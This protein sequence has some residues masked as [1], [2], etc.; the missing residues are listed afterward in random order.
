MKYSD[1]LINLKET[2]MTA[3]HLDVGPLANVIMQL[4]GKPLLT[5]G[6]GGS[7]S[8]A[9]FAA[10]LHEFHTRAIAR[11]V[12]PLEMI[13]TSIEGVGVLCF[14]ASGRNRDICAS[15]KIAAQREVRPLAA[16]TMADQSPLHDLGKIFGYSEITSFPSAD[17]RDG[18]LAVASLIAAAVLVVRA[19]RVVVGD[20]TPLPEDI[21]ELIESATGIKDRSNIADIAEPAVSMSSISVLH[22][23]TLKPVAVDLES[24]F[25]EAA[26]GCLHTADLRNFGH[27]RHHW[28]AKRGEET[29]V[30]AFIGDGQ[31]KLAS[32]TFALLPEASPLTSFNFTGPRDIQALAGLIVGLH[33]AEAAGRVVG[34]DPAKPGVPEFGRKL[35]RL[36]P[37]PSRR[38]L[39]EDHFEV[40]VRRK[41]RNANLTQQDIRDKWRI[42]YETVLSRV[43]SAEIAGIVFDYDGTL[44]DTRHRF[45][46]LSKEIAA[47]LARLAEAGALIGIATGRGGSAG[48]ALRSSLPKT[49]WDR[50]LIGYY[51]GSVL[52]P[53]ADIDAPT[54]VSAGGPLKDLQ[55]ALSHEPPFEGRHSRG[56]AWQI[57]VHLK[58]GDDSLYAIS[59]A[60]ALLERCAISGHVA[61]S[62]HSIDIILGDTSKVKVV[63]AIRKIAEVKHP[64]DILR[65]GD[66]GRWPGNDAE[67]LDNPLGLTVDEA[68][69]NPDVCWALSPPGVLGVQATLYYLARLSWYDDHGCLD[70]QPRRRK[71]GS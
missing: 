55:T 1:A 36:G 20:Y 7:Y 66:R 39:G 19:Y 18:F 46:P 23:G 34:I 8:S 21:D 4:T 27:G 13:S 6:S 71:G 32:R 68:S 42:A 3:R 60:E 14:S 44:C 61:L 26:L 58:P 22:T 17:F 57:T 45:H 38:N 43:A 67:L 12:T 51:N 53:L 35:Y 56:N 59:A 52:A 2:Y 70:I 24:R 25:V 16:L 31:A 69:P 62:G 10:L 63:E 15:F 40:A 65:I 30:V 11:P 64:T 49:L 5:V 9:S 33:V 28:F 37:G 47:A 50:F 29:G 41:D 54:F 48:E